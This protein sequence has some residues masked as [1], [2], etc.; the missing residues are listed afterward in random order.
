MLETTTVSIRRVPLDVLKTLKRVARREG[1]GAGDGPVLLW[2]ATQFALGRDA[3]E[4]DQ[5]DA[6]DPTVATTPPHGCGN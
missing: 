2:A 5:N 1:I 6:H 3:A 4:T